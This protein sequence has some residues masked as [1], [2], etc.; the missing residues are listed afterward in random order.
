MSV[1]LQ[2]I[3]D[4]AAKKVCPNCPS[5]PSLFSY[6]NI[7]L[8]IGG[9]RASGDEGVHVRV[10]VCVGLSLVLSVRVMQVEGTYS[11]HLSQVVQGEKLNAL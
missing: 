7:C 8:P 4:C 2:Y 10:S 1:Y 3:A 5:P 11:G 9:V 6:L